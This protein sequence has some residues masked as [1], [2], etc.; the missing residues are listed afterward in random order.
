MLEI[1]TFDRKDIP[2]ALGLCAQVN[3]NHVAADWER[4]LTLNPEGCLGGFEGGE[5]KATCTLTPFG[6]VGWVG[7]FLVDQALRGKGCGKAIFEAILDK[8]RQ[9]GIE[10]LGLDSSDAGRP[11]YLKYGFQMTGQGIELWTGPAAVAPE[12]GSDSRPLCSADWDSL[13]AFDWECV[14]VSRERQLKALAEAPGATARVIVEGGRVRAFGFSRSG[15][16]T[17]AIGPVVACDAHR[18]GRIVS[19]LMADRQALD[20]GKAVGLVLL[21]NAGFREWLVERGFQSRRRNIRM[22]R[23]AFRD[24][25]TGPTVFVSTGLGMG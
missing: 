10:C 12:S 18:T 4:C 1:K 7:T 24:V 16:M 20:G 3:W 13:V 19:A 9:Q 11:I 14:K 15:R 21:D 22:F 8:A 5:L 25:L 23:P 17:G 6:T 2:A